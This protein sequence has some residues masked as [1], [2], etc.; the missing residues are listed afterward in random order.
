MMVNNQ[1]H[2]LIMLILW[3]IAI[4]T[5][6]HF[7]GNTCLEKKHSEFSLAKKLTYKDQENL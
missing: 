2:M 5:D 7:N 4:G 3:D 6:N 1:H